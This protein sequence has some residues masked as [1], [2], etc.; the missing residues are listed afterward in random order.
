ML[1]QWPKWAWMVLTGVGVVVVGWLDWLTGYEL[2]FFLFYFIPIS[3][4][5]W[6]VGFR[7]ALLLA[8]SSAVAWYTADT[9]SGHVYSS[10]L[11][12]IWNTAVRFVAFL[13]IAYGT[14]KMRYMLDHSISRVKILEGILPI[15]CKCKKIR[16]Q[17]GSWQQ[18]ESY[19]GQHSNAQ[20]SHSYCPECAQKVMEAEGLIDEG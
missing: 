9:Q 16:N 17:V 14:S 6:F 18:L 13:T 11:Y 19:I 3:L 1:E 7:F 10:G 5:A 20:F 4:A 8:V 15:C 2:S 12:E